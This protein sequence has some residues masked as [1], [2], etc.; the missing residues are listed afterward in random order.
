M[1]TIAAFALCEAIIPLQTT[2]ETDSLRM[3]MVEHSWMEG[4]NN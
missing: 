4:T 1:A 2:V 3:V